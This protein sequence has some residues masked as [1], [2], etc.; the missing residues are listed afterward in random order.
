MVMYA[1]LSHRKI[2]GW[3]HLR[4]VEQHNDRD[5]TTPAREED[6]PMPIELLPWSGDMVER[7]RALLTAKEVPHK[8]RKNTVLAYEDVYG[9]SPE[10]WDRRF[11]DGWRTV[12]PDIVARDPLVLAAVRRALD[13]FGEKLVSVR[14]HVDE[15]TPHLHVVSIP[16]VTRMHKQRGRRRADGFVPPP[17]ERTTLYASHVDERGGPGR[18]LEIEH[19]EWAAACAHIRVDG[20]GLE[21]GTRG[22][23]LT[24]EEKRDRSLRAPKA[25]R[26][27]E[28]QAR[29]LGQ[30]R[31]ALADAEKARVRAER[32]LKA[33]DRYA[34]IRKTRD[35][36]GIQQQRDEVA[37]ASSAV[38]AAKVATDRES[39]AAAADRTLAA[40]ELRAT[41][42]SRERSEQAER[43]GAAH[44]AAA[45][46]DR[47]AAASDREAAA[48]TKLDVEHAAQLAVTASADAEAIRNR[49]VKHEQE[50]LESRAAASAAREKADAIL[51]GLEAWA[52]GDILGVSERDGRKVVTY[53][54]SAV[55]D[56]LDVTVKRA[57]HEVWVFISKSAV[58]VAMKI[59]ADE[60]AAREARAAA[61][62]TR[63]EA[64]AFAAGVDAWANGE[65]INASTRARDGAK[66]IGFASESRDRL[67]QILTPAWRQISDWVQARNH[68]IAAELDR[69]IGTEAEQRMRAALDLVTP[70]D[71]EA[72]AA[73]LV[74][75]EQIDKVVAGQISQKQVVSDAYQKH[76]VQQAALRHQSGKGR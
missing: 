3:A 2:R 4:K 54:D 25:S 33:V 13:K 22:S 26:Q 20:L 31:Q 65:I 38:N 72:A 28:E 57:F 42:E 70:A 55:R 58:A 51:I 76:L 46:A 1:T 75:P 15:K 71:I 53:R 27:G 30:Q 10:Y 64:E 48:K 16:L 69:R 40:A 29:L 6:R 73:R 60:R 43:A 14:L 37:A 63:L 19:D 18:R 61:E 17:V 36:K 68:A 59:G 24:E 35:E 66:L 41:Q 52:A 47:L 45:S 8:L 12:D 74:E 5:I 34:R 23:D 44:E 21:R 67:R 9:A 62:Q 32:R 50:I 49:A 7:T 11:P 56:R 39:A